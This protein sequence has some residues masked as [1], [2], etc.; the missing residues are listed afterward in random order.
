MYELVEQDII[1]IP[2]IR[3]SSRPALGL[4][5]ERMDIPPVSWVFKNEG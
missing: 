1:I 3:K 5:F 4:G 2:T